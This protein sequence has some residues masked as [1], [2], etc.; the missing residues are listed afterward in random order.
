L[1][2]VLGARLMHVFVDGFLTDYVHLCVDPMM[3]DGRALQSLEPCT[4]NVECLA[5]QQRGQNIGAICGPEDGLCYPQPDCL[6]PLK[7]WAGGMTVYG[8]LIASISFAYVYIKRRGWDFLR[9]ADMAGYAIFFGLFVG[10]LGCLGAGCCFGDTCD[11]NHWMATTFPVGSTPYDHHFDLHHDELSAHWA[12]GARSSLPVYPTQ[13]ISSA[14]ALAIFAIAY[15]VVR[16]RKRF[17]GQVILTSAILYGVCR[18]L[19]EFFRADF[20]G[21]ALGLS[22]SQLISIPIILGAVVT[23]VLLRQ[24]AALAAPGASAASRA[25]SGGVEDALDPPKEHEEE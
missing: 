6:R 9:M 4:S 11:P 12:T 13:L 23:L 17:H 25:S 24:R 21:G 5:E 18:F 16:P 7:F 2:G 19:I 15:F 20:R 14:Y 8:G 3:L 1:M 22:T 10:R